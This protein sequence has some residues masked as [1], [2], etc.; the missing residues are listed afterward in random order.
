MASTGSA[1]HSGTRTPSSVLTAM[2]LDPARALGALRLSL[3]RWTAAEDMETAAA[4]LI[5]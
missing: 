2:G 5:R 4:A 3:G 1:C